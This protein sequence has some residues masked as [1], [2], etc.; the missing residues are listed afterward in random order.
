MKLRNIFFV[1]LVLAGIAILIRSAVNSATHEVNVNLTSKVW[2]MSVS[3]ETIQAVEY[4]HEERSYA[5]AGAYNTHCWSESHLEDEETV[6][7]YYCDYTMDE[8]RHFRY[9]QAG[10]ADFLPKWEQPV[11]VP[12]ERINNGTFGETYELTFT[13]TSG[14]VYIYHPDNIGEYQSFDGA[15]NIVL[16]VNKKGEV[17]GYR[18]YNQP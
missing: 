17:T 11:L 8:W 12:G 2:E 1:I 18:F 6:Y 16:I 15:Q 7:N 5:P 3:I 13:D 9:G 4:N 10:A 14:N